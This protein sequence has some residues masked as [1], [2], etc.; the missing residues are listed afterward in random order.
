MGTF[1]PSSVTVL[2]DSVLPKGS[3]L[4]HYLPLSEATEIVKWPRNSPIL[5]SILHYLITS[6]PGPQ[7]FG[8]GRR[9]TFS[10]RPL[11]TDIAIA[12]TKLPLSC[13]ANYCFYVLGGNSISL[14]KEIW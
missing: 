3:G 13:I 9:T 1:S 14:G 8:D 2:Y 11:A 12:P 4:Y 7:D 5:V 6:L 10:F